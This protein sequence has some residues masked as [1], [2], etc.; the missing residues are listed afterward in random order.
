[1]VSKPWNEQLE[2]MDAPERTL[3]AA[4][5]KVLKAGRV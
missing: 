4:R 3:N 5:N 1:M 2:L